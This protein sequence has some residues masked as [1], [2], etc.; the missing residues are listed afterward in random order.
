M[1]G[2]A[3]ALLIAAFTAG[4]FWPLQAGLPVPESAPAATAATVDDGVYDRILLASVADH[5]ERSER[6]LTDIMNAPEPGDISIQQAWAEDLL[7]TSRI[8]RQD[9]TDA[10]E[11]SVAIVLDELERNL[12]EIVHSPSQ[13]SAP[14]L[15]QMRR[16]IDAAALLFK[17]RVMSDELRRRE[18]PAAPDY[19]QPSTSKTS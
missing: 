17:V 2:S 9:A 11:R 16:R 1:A 12:I 10:G 7:Q 6:L 3:A 18:V 19:P 14:D 5:L 15:E 4:R 8:Y 13:I